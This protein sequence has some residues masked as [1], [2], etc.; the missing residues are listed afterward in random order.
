M[1]PVVGREAGSLGE[2]RE[3]K[4]WGGDRAAGTSCASAGQAQKEAVCWAPALI[5]C[6]ARN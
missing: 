3:G 6:R 5:L 2:G 4:S 1:G